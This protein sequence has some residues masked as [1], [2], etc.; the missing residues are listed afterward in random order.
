MC[1]GL[2]IQ[3]VGDIGLEPTTSRVCVSTSKNKGNDTVVPVGGGGAG[4]RP[5]A[6]GDQNDPDLAK[7]ARDWAVL[8]PA[9]KAGI[10]AM[11]NAD[12]GD[13]T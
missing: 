3:K 12:T 9:V 7:L 5:D 11:V 8:S 1:A 10:M 6:P 4:A 2:S 13:K